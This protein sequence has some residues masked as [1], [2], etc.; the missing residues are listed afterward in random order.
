[1]KEAW[2]KRGAHCDTTE[3]QSTVPNAALLTKFALERL[4]L[5]ARWNAKRSSCV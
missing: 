4:E 3:V 2:K 1:M 5:A